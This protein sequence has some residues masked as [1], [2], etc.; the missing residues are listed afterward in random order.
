MTGS[1]NKI[2]TELVITGD[3]GVDDKNNVKTVKVES[4]KQEK[5][6][7]SVKSVKIK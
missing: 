3:G 1:V 6:I 5:A 4:L 2:G 7:N